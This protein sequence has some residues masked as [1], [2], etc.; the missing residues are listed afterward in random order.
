M[1]GGRMIAIGKQDA[2]ERW[3]VLEILRRTKVME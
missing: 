2:P 3:V 1:D